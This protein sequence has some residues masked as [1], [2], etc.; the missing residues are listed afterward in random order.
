LPEKHAA[1]TSTPGT[2]DGEIGFQIAPMVDVVFVLMLFFMACAGAQ[3]IPRDLDANLPASG[4]GDHAAIVVEIA[5][6]DGVLLNGQPLGESGDRELAALRDWFRNIH[7]QFGADHPV[8]VRPS[9]GTRHARVIDVLNALK[10]A[11][12]DKVSF[13]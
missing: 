1:M 2:H 6:D 7:R 5:P 12:V 3:I 8:M 4:R 10:A 11:E 9:G 13:L